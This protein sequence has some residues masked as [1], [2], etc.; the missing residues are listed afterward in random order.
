[1]IRFVIALREFFHAALPAAADLPSIYE[2]QQHHVFGDLR[3]GARGSP[4]P[5]PRMGSGD[6]SDISIDMLSRSNAPALLSQRVGRKPTPLAGQ[7]IDRD[8]LASASAQ[9]E[10]TMLLDTT[11]DPASND[12]LEWYY[13]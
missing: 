9:F 11:T 7:S 1:M 8:L 13:R 2:R 12:S 10:W 4:F 5:H 6:P 3:T